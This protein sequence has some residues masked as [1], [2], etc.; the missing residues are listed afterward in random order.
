[1][2]QSV[3]VRATAPLL[4]PKTPG[5]SQVVNTRSV[6]EL[7]VNGRN[8]LNLTEVVPGVV[9]QARP[10]GTRSPGRTFSRQATP[11]PE[12]ACWRKTRH[13]I[14]T[15]FRPTPHWAISST[16]CRARRSFRVPRTDLCGAEY[17]V[18]G[19]VI[20]IFFRSRALTSITARVEYFRNHRPERQPLLQQRTVSR[21][22]RHS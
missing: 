17:G 15:V 9:P 18:A 14:T 10:A 20:N 16:W 1:M 22:R 19:G 3:E 13:N 11:D 5:L 8:I 7:P 12:A 21:E 2:T 6:E 4:E